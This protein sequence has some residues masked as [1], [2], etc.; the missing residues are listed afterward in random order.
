MLTWF[1]QLLTVCLFH[2][3]ESGIESEWRLNSCLAK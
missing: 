3:R 1:R 2:V